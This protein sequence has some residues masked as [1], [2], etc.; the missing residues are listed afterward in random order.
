[1]VLLSYQHQPAASPYRAAGPI[2]V[3]EGATTTYD[4]VGPAPEQLRRRLLSLR[5]YD[6]EDCIVEAEVIEGSEVEALAERFLADP[7]VAYL[8]AHYARRGCY[9][10]RIERG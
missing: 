8:H 3:R 1:M 10:C 9:A 4:A 2:F 6:R 7:A 5:A